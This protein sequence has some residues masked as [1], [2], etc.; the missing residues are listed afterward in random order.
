MQATAA[1]Y[2]QRLAPATC[3]RL[4]A[5]SVPASRSCQSRCPDC[6]IESRRGVGSRAFARV[7]VF[8]HRGDIRVIDTTRA[9]VVRV[10]RCRLWL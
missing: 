7:A 9:A 3:S 10:D 6:V 5:V 2:A 4:A 1:A 8:V